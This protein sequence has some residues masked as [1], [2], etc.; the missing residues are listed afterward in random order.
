[1][2]K[3]TLVYLVF[4][5]LFQT[6]AVEP[7]PISYG[8]DH[9]DFCR[10]KIMDARYGAEIVT[11]KGKT[12]KFDAIECLINYKKRNEIEESTLAWTM[13]TDYTNPSQ[14]VNASDCYYLRAK[15]LPS[16]MGMSLTGLTDQKT[17]MEIQKEHKGE[18]YDWKE[19]NNEFDHLPDL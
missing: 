5:F 14:L 7:E 1:M 10:M 6:C 9:C 18:I 15:S 19:L 8:I 3:K 4:M 16:P 2:I 12:F 11:Q 17:A 13:I